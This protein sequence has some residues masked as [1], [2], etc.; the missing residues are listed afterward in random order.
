[1][2]TIRLGPLDRSEARE[3]GAVLGFQ[4]LLQLD[5]IENPMFILLGSSKYSRVR[6]LGCSVLLLLCSYRGPGFFLGV[7]S[8]SPAQDGRM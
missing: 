6:C 3:R 4:Y 1:M 7:F 8:V 5:G 2:R